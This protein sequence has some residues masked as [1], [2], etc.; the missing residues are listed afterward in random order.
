MITLAVTGLVAGAIVL[1]PAPAEA[2]VRPTPFEDVVLRRFHQAVNEYVS[3]HRD[4]ER[5]L[6][7]L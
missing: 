2:H 1:P 4:V 5:S 6:P 3:L 7:P